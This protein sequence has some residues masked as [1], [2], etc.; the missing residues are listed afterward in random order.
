MDRAQFENQSMPS[1]LT[2]KASDDGHLNIGPKGGLCKGIRGRAQPL[3]YA[4][5]ALAD[6]SPFISYVI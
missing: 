2:H 6:I 4:K 1:P 3:P 5:S